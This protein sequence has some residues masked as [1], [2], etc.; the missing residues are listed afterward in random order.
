M[1]SKLSSC[2]FSTLCIILYLTL[3]ANAQ[4]VHIPDP[5]L[6]ASIR[7]ELGWPDD[8]PL[9]AGV[10]EALERLGDRGI[11][12]DLTG[13]EHAVNLWE[14]D[15][16]NNEIED[17]SPIAGLTKLIDLNLRSNP[18]RNFKPL[19]N[20]TNLRRLNLNGTPI[21]NLT[22]LANLINLE[23]LLLEH[24]NIVDVTLL[25]NLINLKTLDLGKNQI[26]DVSPLANLTQLETLR[27][28]ENR[29]NDISPLLGL[30]IQNLEYDDVRE[31][32]VPQQPVQDRIDNRSLPSI[33]TGWGDGLS[34]ELWGAS[35]SFEERGAL[36]DLWWRNDFSELRYVLTDNGPGSYRT[37]IIGDWNKVINQDTELASLNPNM[38]RLVLMRQKASRIG[39]WPEDW[40][41]WQRDENGDFV[42]EITF[43]SD[44]AILLDYQSPEVH[45]AL[46]QRA[47]AVSQCGIYDGI[48]FDGWGSDRELSQRESY[49]LLGKI[50]AAVPDDFL[51]LFRTGGYKVPAIIPYINGAYM[52]TFPSVRGAGYTLD[53]IIQIEEALIWYEANV[54]EPKINC[55][56]GWGLGDEPPDSPNNRQYMRLFTTMSLTCSNGYSLYTLGHVPGRP[57]LD[58]FQDHIW[59]S[60]WN[61]DLGQPVD[62]PVR[63]PEI[64]G[65]HVRQ[66]TNGW[67]AYN[68]SGVAQ[69][70]NFSYNVSGVTSELSGT[71]HIVPDLDGEIYLRVKP[72]NPADV[73][74]DGIVN[75]LDLTLVAQG[76]STNDQ[77]VD[78]NGDGVVNV[79]DL[80]F[81][82]KQFE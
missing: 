50:R 26:I 24:C 48:Q 51:I 36:H 42:H 8:I 19:A 14:L 80:V 65:F 59:Y 17:I 30:S 37:T 6:D 44:P 11:I 82:A 25:A 31:C 34:G 3:T 9:T 10:M 66:F 4:I 49:A 74:K 45:D 28:K 21:S 78:I 58:R 16:S 71:E 35:L 77:T 23:E 47:V 57:E 60:F 73:N 13:L 79:F 32:M 33:F 54:R 40:L 18:I 27:L 41:G 53:D 81:I 43:N 15:M 55:L 20:L 75:I 62:E 56:R 12:H 52:E 38:I 68:R 7:H 46:V 64:E 5:N 76:I 63:K 72:A 70:V 67:A 29:Y 69:T 1:N 61:A 39:H 22:P 2:L